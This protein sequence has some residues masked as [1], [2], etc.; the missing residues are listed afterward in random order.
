VLGPI[1][2]FDANIDFTALMPADGCATFRYSEDSIMS[3]VVFTTI[4]GFGSTS[5]VETGDNYFLQPDGGT[6]VELNYTGAPVVA[7][8]FGAWT[9][10][11]AEQMASGCEEAWKMTGTD[12][13]TVWNTDNSGNYPSSVYEFASGTSAAL[14]S[15]ETKFHQDLNGDG[16]IGPVL[17]GSSDAQ[18]LA[19]G[20]RPTMLIGG[21]ND[22]S[23]AAPARPHLRSCR[24]WCEYGQRFQAGYGSAAIQPINVCRRYRRDPQCSP[25]RIR[26][27]DLI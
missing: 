25:G 2:R 18:A 5:L 14:L 19:A 4:E 11:G 15:F 27:R 13:Y 20:R 8:Q 3:D 24:T 16:Y 23:L 26:R 12:Q 10:I 9:P 7:G 17:S 21:P 6:A 22:S 1:E